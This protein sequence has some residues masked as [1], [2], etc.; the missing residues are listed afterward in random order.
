[1]PPSSAIFEK[2]RSA[3]ISQPLSA[4]W[5]GHGS[6]IFLEFGRL[7]PQ[8]KRDG[9]VGNSQGDYTVMIEWSW[10][11]E[12]EDAILC[13]SWS[14]E[15]GW[16]GVFKSLIGREVQ[17]VSIYGRLPELSVTLTGGLYVAS[18]MTAEG[19]PEWTIF[20][21]CAEQQK[22]AHIAVRNGQI[23]EDWGAETAQSSPTPIPKLPEA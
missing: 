19:Q 10:R 21:R 6:A 7:F 14:D 17:D 2:Y 3:L 16:D 15:E 4:V 8:V 1:M 9:S 5:R 13:G 11:I 22:S 18:F 20:D 12:V 23:Y